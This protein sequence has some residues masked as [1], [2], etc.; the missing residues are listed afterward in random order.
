[1]LILSCLAALVCLI[2]VVWMDLDKGT[3]FGRVPWSTWIAQRMLPI[4]LSSSTLYSIYF[5]YFCWML[6][7]GLLFACH[8]VVYSA[9]S[10]IYHRRV[11]DDKST[12]ESLKSRQKMKLEELK[13]RFNYYTTKDLLERFEAGLKPAS[14]ANEEGTLR[15]RDNAKVHPHGTAV[16]KD[17]FA[18]PPSTSNSVPVSPLA[19]LAVSHFGPD[20]HPATIP[21][22]PSPPTVDRSFSQWTLSQAQSQAPLVLP[23]PRT[24][25]DRLLDALIGQD[26]L[27]LLQGSN[28]A[29]SSLSHLENI[30]ALICIYCGGHNGLVN[31]V[32]YERGLK[33]SCPKCGQW[34]DP[35]LFRD[36]AHAPPFPEPSSSRSSEE[37]SELAAND[38]ALLPS[39]P[40]SEDDAAIPRATPESVKQKGRRSGKGK[41]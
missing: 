29:S 28:E 6:F 1:M 34:N 24:W 12:L 3:L 16:D 20:A 33:Y 37:V 39:L 27:S 21:L 2:V 40:P 23:A 14:A 32:E 31:R 8:F 18:P 35:S 13:K 36:G 38:S 25:M 7:F 10:Y 30:F 15:K 17:H 9:L 41:A 19:P 5:C 4:Q 11:E 22:P 26:P